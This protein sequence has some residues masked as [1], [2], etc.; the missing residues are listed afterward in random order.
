MRARSLRIEA[1][2]TYGAVQHQIGLRLLEA[3]RVEVEAQ[4]DAAAGAA[5]AVEARLE[6]RA[7]WTACS[8]DVALERAFKSVSIAITELGSELRFDADQLGLWSD[9]DLEVVLARLEAPLRLVIEARFSVGGDGASAEGSASVEL[10]PAHWWAGAAA[11][12]E[13]LAAYMAVDDETALRC[14]ELAES[15]VGFEEVVAILAAS[16]PLSGASPPQRGDDLEVPFEVR[17]AVALQPA[18]GSEMSPLEC[19]LGFAAALEVAGRAV[20]VVRLRVGG[21]WR[22]FVGVWLDAARFEHAVVVERA[23]LEGRLAEGKI[24]VLDLELLATAMRETAATA[25]PAD[26]ASTETNANATVRAALEASRTCFQAAEDFDFAIDVATARLQGV[27]ARRTAPKHAA[28]TAPRSRLEVWK[29]RLLD[30]SLRNRLLHHRET[31]RVVPLCS[32]TAAEVAVALSSDKS[33]TIATLEGHATSDEGERRERARALVARGAFPTDIEATELERRLVALYREGAS[34]LAETGS[35]TLHMALGFLVWFE[36]ARSQVPRFAPLLLVPVELERRSVQRGIQVRLADEDV[37]IN[38]TLIEKLRVDFGI[39]VATPLLGDDGG[40]GDLAAT[41]ER[42]LLAF[43]QAVALRRRFEVVD[44][45]R[46]ASFSFTKFLMWRDLDQHEDLVV[47]PPVLRRVRGLEPREETDVAATELSVDGSKPPLAST[48]APMLADS[49]QMSAIL[50]A[51]AGQSFVLEGPP[52]TG[53]SQTIA[54]LIANALAH[55]KRVLF[56]AEKTAALDVVHRRLV[57]VGLGDFCLE[58]HSDKATKRE[59]MAQLEQSLDCERTQVG[60]DFDAVAARLEGARAE[61][62]AYRHALHGRRSIGVSLH[63]A[64]LRA[65]GPVATTPGSAGS[66]HAADAADTA[67]L[68]ALADACLGDSRIEDWRPADLELFSNLLADLGHSAEPLRPLAD[69]GLRSIHTVH[70]SVERERTLHD[71]ATRGVD[72]LRRLEAAWRGIATLFGAPTEAVD[73]AARQELDLVFALAAL[74]DERKLATTELLRSDSN[75]DDVGPGLEAARQVAE[76]AL[77]ERFDASILD[78]EHAPLLAALRRARDSFFLLRWW[79][80]RAPRAVLAPLAKTRLAGVAELARDVE[81]AVRL[82]GLRPLAESAAARLMV[83]LGQEWRERATPFVAARSELEHADRIVALC[84]R[85]EGLGLDLEKV[86]VVATS[87]AA[88]AA[89][90]QVT[91]NVA[92]LRAARESLDAVVAALRDDFDFDVAALGAAIWGEDRGGGE[93]KS[94]ALR[95]SLECCAGIAGDASALRD[96]VAW[97]RVVEAAAG[98]GSPQL[99]EATAKVFESLSAAPRDAFV[100]EKALLLCAFWRRFVERCLAQ[101]AATARF[102]RTT[103]EGLVRRFQEL[104]SEWMLRGRHALRARLSERLPSALAS[105][106]PGSEVALLRRELKKRSRHMPIRQLLT[107]TSNLVARLKPCFLMSPMSVARYLEPGVAEPFD[108]VVFDEASQIPPWDAAFAIARGKSVVVVGDSKQLPPTM[109]FTKEVVQEGAGERGVADDAEAV[110]D[111][112]SILDECSVAGLPRYDLRWHYRSEHEALIAFSNARYYGGRLNTFPAARSADPELGVSFRHVTGTYDRAKSATNMVEARTIV[113]EIEE[114]VRR[115]DLRS[116]GVVTFSQAQQTLIEDL[117]DEARRR[118][119]AFDEALARDDDEGL[120][121]K[122][123]ENVQGDERDVIFFSIGYGPDAEGKVWL[124]FGPLNKV[125]GERRLNVAITRARQQVVVFSSL[126]ADDIDT[127]RIAA[128]SHGVRHLRAFLDYAERGTLSSDGPRGQAVDLETIARTPLVRAIEARGFE[129]ETA[130]GASAFR[131]DVAVRDRGDARRFVLAVLQDG[132]SW[133]SAVAARDRELLRELVLGRLGW[134]IERVFAPEWVYGRDREIARVLERLDRAQREADEAREPAASAVQVDVAPP[135]EPPAEA[136]GQ[137]SSE[138]PS[139]SSD[140]VH[141][142]PQAP[143]PV[144]SDAA[145]APQVN[146]ALQLV[147]ASLDPEANARAYRLAALPSRAGRDFDAPESLQVIADDLAQVLEVEAPIERDLLFRRVLDAWSIARLTKRIEAQLAVALATTP[148]HVVEEGSEMI[149]W[150]READA[151]SYTTWRGPAQ[152][153]FV[154]RP[155]EV[156]VLEIAN[157]VREVLHA[158]ISIEENDLVRAVS[159]C[160]GYARLGR[161]IEVAVRRGIA[162]LVERGEAERVDTRVRVPAP[163]AVQRPMT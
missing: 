114:R 110:L 73:A 54:C 135:L 70:W 41:V 18:A 104:D 52:G 106:V 46:L 122:N 143:L 17:S 72:A 152:D 9:A 94:H 109:F 102:H 119:T 88:S 38:E 82:R 158:A 75:V 131:V 62:D 76:A 4:S 29:Q 68:A 50:A 129:V 8:E 91:E 37:A 120:F 42:V 97:N 163:S 19:V 12:V 69:H 81:E 137:Q 138:Q 125:G 53:K 139:D 118:D 10:V 147:S 116:I 161:Q 77:F 105:I 117:I 112:E 101:D 141:A 57:K 5:T 92:A 86:G 156:P 13:A 1:P 31:K 80:G 136:S 78:L 151:G 47:A 55:G 64:M 99:A 63:E 140:V 132:S 103:H 150:K 27:Q 124:N 24:V 51:A 56:V 107:R 142:R 162:V 126:R 11:P 33:F 40:E 48:F 44:A 2:T 87:A 21:A 59:V 93:D 98:A 3:I 153:G 144:N 60:E 71:L 45:C 58:L 100:D 65:T 15:D 96:R 108:I 14:T 121:V 149:L 39:E 66:A 43:R 160:L 115:G 6:V 83:L 20:L 36:D 113:A 85:L 32:V 111:L 25:L 148:C 90:Q 157:A 23:A 95:R 89:A 130:V 79:R 49:S 155:H 35:N 34:S 159:K 26:E 145:A 128:S 7:S 133:A 61:L 67:Q 30:L 16:L 74:I 22:Y 123:L 84:R 146:E 154:R 28:A 134:S 127:K